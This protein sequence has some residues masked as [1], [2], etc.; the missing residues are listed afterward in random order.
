MENK[1]NKKDNK[2]YSTE[3]IKEALDTKELKEALGKVIKAVK[4]L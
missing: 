3:F 1:G 2:S 4:E